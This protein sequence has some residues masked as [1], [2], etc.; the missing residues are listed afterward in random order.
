[1]KIAT[2]N[3][4]NVNKRLANLLE[5]MKESEP[6]VVCLQELKAAQNAFPEDAINQVGYDAVWVGQKTWNGVAILSRIG[7]PLV[8][9]R[10]LPGDSTDTQARYIEAAVQGVLIACIYA[11]NGNPQPGPKFDYKLQWLERLRKRATELRKMGAPV[12]LAGDFN[13]VPT[14]FDIYPTKSWD[15]DALVQPEARAAFRKLV[16]RSWTDALRQL[17]PEERIY[18]FWHYMRNRWE[19]DAGL[20]ID[21][22]LLSQ[23]LRHR[24]AAAGVDR[25]VRGRQNAS[26]HAPVW[27]EL[28]E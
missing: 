23:N 7:E 1:M 9:C 4:N 19:R 12:V 25:E 26:D 27:I 21:H 14:E 13:V 11:P 28:S 20:R 16:G 22:L 15:K 10:Q 17:H 2:F 5:W 24:L 8:T 3:I 6:D 18:T